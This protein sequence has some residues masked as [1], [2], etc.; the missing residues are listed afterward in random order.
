MRRGFSLVFGL[1]MV[2]VV[3]PPA[4]ADS[5][6]RTALVRRGV[7]PP[8]RTQLD[9]SIYARSDCGPAALGMVLADYGVVEDTLDLRGLAHAAQGT[10]P[11]VRAGPALQHVA[12]GA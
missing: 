8:Y 7:E 1:L 10:G 12:H 4:Q 9:D 6:Y 2:C 3:A 11:A 5:W